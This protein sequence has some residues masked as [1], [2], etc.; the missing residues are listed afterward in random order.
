M[1]QSVR[2]FLLVLPNHNVTTTSSVPETYWGE[3]LVAREQEGVE[4]LLN[5]SCSVPETGMLYI[6]FLSTDSYALTGFDFIYFTKS[7][8]PG[9]LHKISK[10]SIVN[11]IG[12]IEHDMISV[13]TIYI[14]YV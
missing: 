3:G 8:M 9:T 13:K 6:T 11:A 14:V 7:K 1:M 4:E 2:A 12:D 10:P 5:L